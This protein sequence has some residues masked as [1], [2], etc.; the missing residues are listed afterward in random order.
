MEAAALARRASGAV[1]R[2]YRAFL[3]AAGA[4]RE[5]WAVGLAGLEL[6]KSKFLLV[7]HL[8]IIF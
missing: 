6:W 7:S 1:H 4:L 2:L 8:P 5:L 3:E